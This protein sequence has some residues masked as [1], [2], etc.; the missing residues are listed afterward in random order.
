MSFEDGSYDLVVVMLTI[1]SMQVLCLLWLSFERECVRLQQL[2]IPLPEQDFTTKTGGVS[3]S[4]PSVST[5]KPAT[6]YI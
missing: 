5:A 1:P 3:S 2:A 4:L 6:E